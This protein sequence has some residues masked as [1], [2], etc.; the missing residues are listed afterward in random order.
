MSIRV[1]AL[2]MTQVACS[3][4]FAPV[5]PAPRG[6]PPFRR[7]VASRAARRAL[8]ASASADDDAPEALTPPDAE[9]QKAPA[10]KAR[11]ASIGFVGGGAMAEAIARGFVAG[12]AARFSDL[13][14][15][16]GSD[17][18]TAARWRA[19]DVDV[20]SSNAEI[21]DR[22]DVV[23]FAVKPHIL[24]GVLN[25]CGA[26]V[27]VDRH[28]FVSVA[29]GVSSSFIEDSLKKA[30]SKGIAPGRPGP[31]AMPSSNKKEIAEKNTRVV[32]VSTPKVVRVMP[33]TP[34]LVGEAAS[35]ACKGSAASDE[36]VTFVVE[37]MRSCG[38]CLNVSSESLLDAVTGVS[39]SGPAYAFLFIEALADG[40]V[41]AGLPRSTATVLAA[42]TVLGAAKM[43]LE[44][45]EHPGALKDKV[46]SPGGATIQAVRALESN[47]FR[48]AAMEAVLASA[49]KSRELGI[50]SEKQHRG[51]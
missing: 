44:T 27:D 20:L 13:A 2:D 39:G 43:V 22:C 41:A 26:H 11:R 38:L 10:P 33:N 28:L 32:T 46:C 8:A 47:G 4:A 34:C 36:D 35:A 23:I 1:S 37:L 15:S 7:R 5:R 50:E 24:P 21:L 6:S 31:G 17:P 25:E 40:G 49:T 18:A 19:L 3:S 30:A 45:G 42:Q 48:S 14:V 29:A 16:H 9:T 51:K 12:G